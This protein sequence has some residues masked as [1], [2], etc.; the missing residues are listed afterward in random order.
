MKKV[1]F[2]IYIFAFMFLLVSSANALSYSEWYNSVETAADAML[3]ARNDD[4]SFDWKQDGDSTNSGSINTQGATGR[5]LVAAYKVTGKQEYLD[6]ANDTANWLNS[7]AGTYLYNK[8]V[9]F[10]YELAAAGGQD[11]TSFASQNAKSYINSK[12]GATGAQAVYDHYLN[13]NWVSDSGTMDGLKLWMLGEWGHV[14]QLLGSYEISSGYTGTVFAQ[15]MG[16]L[17]NDYYPSYDPYND[18]TTYDSYGTLGLVG[19]LEGMFFG[20]SSFANENDALYALLDKPGLGWQDTGYKTYALSL[21][22][23]NK[24]EQLSNWIIDGYFD[25]L[26]VGS[27]LESQGEALLGVASAPVP[28][29]TTW[30]LF[31]TGLLGLLGF[32]RKKFFKKL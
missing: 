25:T 22:G 26:S 7:N 6:A 27:Y 17:L 4:G 2:A 10:M 5:G 24:P 3:D 29:P 31:G 32:G 28:E 14:G 1:F 13:M 8:D 15:E 12:S 16:Q 19:M 20:G 23:I 21:Y 11:Y 18:P 30:L 9:E